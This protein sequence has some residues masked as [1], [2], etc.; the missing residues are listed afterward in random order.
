M[1]L[2]YSGKLSRG[3]ASTS[4]FATDCVMNLPLTLDS[5]VIFAVC[6]YR[7]KII[8][9]FEDYEDTSR[10]SKSKM[11]FAN[12]QRVADFT[13]SDIALLRPICS[14]FGL[15]IAPHLRKF[16][17]AL[18]SGNTLPAVD[19]ETSVEL[20]PAMSTTLEAPTPFIDASRRLDVLPAQAAAGIVS[21]KNDKLERLTGLVDIHSNKF[22]ARNRSLQKE[23]ER[24]RRRMNYG[25][26]HVGASSLQIRIESTLRTVLY[27]CKKLV[28]ADR[29]TIFY[30]DEKN[31]QLFFNVDQDDVEIRIPLNSGIAGEVALK[32]RTL[33]IPDAYKDKRFN[34]SV[35]KS[36]GYKT[37][38][39]LCVPVINSEN[40]A[41][42]VIQM[43]NKKK[44]PAKRNRLVGLSAREAREMRT[45]TQLGHQDWLEASKKKKTKIIH[46]LSRMKINSLRLQP[47]SAMRLE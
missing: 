28:N 37:R 8:P 40:R 24:A 18:L 43:I 38:S 6:Q 20:P 4:G 3:D 21:E 10:H 46:S 29:C 7:N 45:P 44:E 41:L 2:E 15:E 22:G 16:H 34:T 1:E 31:D 27:Q 11:R 35:D 32:K 33:N 14:H 36:T 47:I 9:G 19:V 23:K 12:G 13:R 26:K 30:V 17:K 25:N 5:G 42:A 39:I